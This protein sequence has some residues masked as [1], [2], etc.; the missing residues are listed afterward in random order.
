MPGKHGWCA[1]NLSTAN[2]PVTATKAAPGASDCH[3]VYGVDAA[4]SAAPT[5]VPQI[6]IKDGDANVLWQG[7]VTSAPFVREF[8][9]GLAVP[10]GKAV[11][12]TLNAG[13]AGVL[14]AVNL[15]GKTA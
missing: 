4:F 12:V 8:P 3:V 2:A 11:S 15:D 14:G 13:G 1:T 5:G 10:Q 7:Y 9:A 6:Q